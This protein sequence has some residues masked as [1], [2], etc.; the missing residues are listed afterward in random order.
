VQVSARSGESL[1]WRV[2]RFVLNTKINYL[3]DTVDAIV[4]SRIAVQCSATCQGR[5]CKNMKMFFTLDDGYELIVQEYIRDHRPIA[6]EEAI[7]FRS[8]K[9]LSDAIVEAASC[10][11]PSGK[12][13]PHQYRV[14]VTSL[15]IARDRLLVLPLSQC[16]TFDEIHSMIESAI[17][18]IPEIGALTVYDIAHR[19]GEF[20]RKEPEFVYIHQ[21]S[22]KSTKSSRSETHNRRLAVRDVPDP[23]QKLKAYEVVDCFFIFRNK[24]KAITVPKTSADE[25][26]S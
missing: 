19:I 17:S 3:N 15:D 18:D 13:H 12:P 1:Q 14:P 16:N 4:T 8:M 9:S 2:S 20:L 7:H 11:L 26:E 5:G 24:L 6:N 22:T 23:F 10:N 21:T 25:T